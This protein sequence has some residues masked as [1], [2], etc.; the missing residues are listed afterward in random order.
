MEISA[1]INDIIGFIES[2][3]KEVQKFFDSIVKHYG[4]ED[5]DN[6]PEDF[7]PTTAAKGE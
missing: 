7:N 5:P 6:Y 1:I 2:F 3:M 4:F